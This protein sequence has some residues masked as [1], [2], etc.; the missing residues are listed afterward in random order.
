MKRSIC[1]K[2]FALFLFSATILAPSSANAGPFFLA[3]VSLCAAGSGGVLP[4][5]AACVAATC[6]G[7]CFGSGT[8]ITVLNNDEITTKNIEDVLSGD[9][10]LT[11][12]DGKKSWTRVIRNV[13][14]EGKFEFIEITAKNLAN[15]SHKEIR[16]TPEHGLVL[17]NSVG[18]LT[19]DAAGHLQ[20]GDRIMDSDKNNLVVTHIS[21]TYGDDKYV[22][23]TV[24]GTVL[25]SDLFMTTICDEEVSGGE[26]LFESTMNS[27]KIRHNFS[28][29]L[30]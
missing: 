25:A 13:R 5:A 16:V 17:S 19:I 11:L 12:K 22:L 8:Q 30:Q 23:E 26:K 28:E 15:G 18:Q 7:F 9:R 14:S 29:S 4:L 27:W 2:Y 10:V 24:E 1:S 6:W 21:H 20:V 3:C